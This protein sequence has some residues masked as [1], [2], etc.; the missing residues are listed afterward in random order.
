MSE[1]ETYRGAVQ[2]FLVGEIGI[3]RVASHSGAI[4]FARRP[5]QPGGKEGDQK[6]GISTSEPPAREVRYGVAA[7]EC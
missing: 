3:I 1:Q 6:Q 2:Q 4:L 5:G 7:G